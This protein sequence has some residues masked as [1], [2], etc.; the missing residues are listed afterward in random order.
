MRVTC[1]NTLYFERVR[2]T[3]KLK[4]I[5][6]HY[7]THV[8]NGTRFPHVVQARVRRHKIIPTAVRKILTHV[9]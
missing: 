6:F 3:W 5:V 1:N 2:K 8:Y 9:C 7:T 4:P